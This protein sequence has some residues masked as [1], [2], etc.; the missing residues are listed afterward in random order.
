MQGNKIMEECILSIIQ[1]NNISEQ[2]DLQNMLKEK[3][4]N[5][6]QATLS[7]KLKKMN[8]AKIGGFY[9]VESF[10]PPHAPIILSL[11]ASESG[12]IVLHTH[13]GSASNLAYFID[14]KYVSP[15]INNSDNHKVLGTIA[16]DDTVMLILKQ[17]DDVYPM[18]VLLKKDFP[19]IDISKV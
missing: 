12:I 11:K 14:Q 5:I 19:Y 2:T 15:N 13:P 6:S 4:Q 16:G 7:R 10:I 3:N 1:N 8:I 17:N 18:S 9:K